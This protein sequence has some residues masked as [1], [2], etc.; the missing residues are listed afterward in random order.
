MAIRTI[1]TRGYGNGTFDGSIAEIVTR[2]YTIGEAAPIQTT[3]VDSGLLIILPTLTI[4]RLGWPGAQLVLDQDGTILLD[5]YGQFLTDQNQ[6][7][8]VLIVKPSLK[9]KI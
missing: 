6:T 7:A 5:Q 2:G 3:K 4:R 8:E 9:V 1:I